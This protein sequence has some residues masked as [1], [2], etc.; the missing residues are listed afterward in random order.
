MIAPLKRF[1]MQRILP[2]V[3]DDSLS[4]LEALAK[5]REKLN[6]V[7]E[8]YNN[9]P[10]WESKPETVNTDAGQGAIY[11]DI[12]NSLDIASGYITINTD[13]LTAGQVIC[14]TDM[15]P[16]RNIY[17]TG[18]FND[19]MIQ[20]SIETNGDVKVLQTVGSEQGKVLRFTAVYK[21]NFK[22]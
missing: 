2:L 13:G 21:V 6:E 11:H 3:Y 16:I 19:G 22:E 15:K 1:W 7:I 4:Y 14:N 5:M 9:Y 18:F 20:L 12:F 8:Y 10:E 17:L